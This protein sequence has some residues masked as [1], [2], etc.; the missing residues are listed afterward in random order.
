MRSRATK[1]ADQVLPRLLR[2]EKNREPLPGWRGDSIKGMH[3]R[4]CMSKQKPALP[5][6]LYYRLADAAKLLGCSADDLLHYGAC[7]YLELMASVDE[8][9]ASLFE[10][11]PGEELAYREAGLIVPKCNFIIPLLRN[12]IEIERKGVSIVGEARAVLDLWKGGVR[13]C[14]PEEITLAELLDNDDPELPLYLFY[15]GIDGGLTSGEESNTW[16]ACDVEISCSDLWVRTRELERFGLEGAS[17]VR[18]DP[19]LPLNHKKPHGNAENHARNRE[20]VLRA[21]I[22]VK[23]KFP[24]LCGETNR[25]WAKAIDEKALLFWP[26]TGEPPLTL[27]TIER[28]LGDC[29]KLPNG[30]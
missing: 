20:A 21:A 1:Q 16:K 10:F 26:D 15:L 13:F 6:R 7:G 12:L 8:I 22:A 9:S 29:L 27:D 2:Q 24:D 11:S 30:K 18:V 23:E 25:D 4:E 3:E 19:E 14:L 17:H 28:L 5:A